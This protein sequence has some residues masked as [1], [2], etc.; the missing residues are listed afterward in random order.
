MVDLPWHPRRP[1]RWSGLLG[2]VV[3]LVLLAW[4]LHG[5]PLG[6]LI[7]RLRGVRTLPLVLTVAIATA[8]F[9]LVA[10]R[11]RL[12]LRREGAVPSYSALWHATAIGFMANNLLPA[13]AGEFARAYAARRL[14]G[15]RFTTALATIAV[16][17]VLDGIVLVVLLLVAVVAG[18]FARDASVWGVP[19][20]RVAQGAGVLFGG[21]L[22]V[23]LVLV[24]WP[25]PVV[26]LARS[27]APRVL[28]G[29][30]AERTLVVLQGFL[31]GFEAL[32]RPGSFAVVLFWSFAV[33]LVTA[34]SYW[35]GFQAFDLDL[36]WS[37]AFMIQ[38]VVALGIAV[39]SSPGFVGVF[40]AAARV[41]LALYGLQEGGAVPFALA[42]HLATFLPITMLGLLSLAQAGL[43]V[44]ELR[45]RAVTSDDSG[46]GPRRMG[47]DPT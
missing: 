5:V 31:L 15:A 26:G 21:L 45:A 43:Q 18:G 44:G 40:E 35:V 28:P 22:L 6:E 10:F 32:R 41:A 36:P 39:P 17:R 3:S 13:R 12:L 20:I 1:H 33:W 37:A 8:R 42:Y 46:N 2:I 34:A 14:A 25:Q 16:E 27:V 24:H 23:A 47:D 30:L 19:L 4:A 11:W 29:H 7:S 9:P 38:G